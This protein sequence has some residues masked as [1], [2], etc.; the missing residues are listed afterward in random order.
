MLELGASTEKKNKLFWL[1]EG[2][3]CSR[4]TTWKVF[5]SLIL[6]HLDWLRVT[7]SEVEQWLRES[8]SNKK[9][10]RVRSPV[11]RKNDTNKD[12]V[13]DNSARNSTCKSRSCRRTQLFAS[14]GLSQ[15]I[16]STATW[17][18]SPRITVVYKTK[19]IYVSKD[20]YSITSRAQRKKKRKT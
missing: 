13:G 19:K 9:Q 5:F 12:A 16:D 3:R 1:C 8:A 2:G 10:R 20:F 7:F 4:E 6:L 11:R 17:G 14:S 18:Y 15:T